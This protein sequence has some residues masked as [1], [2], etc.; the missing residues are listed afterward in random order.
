VVLLALLL[1]GAGAAPTTGV[2]ADV[3]RAAQGIIAADN[4]SDIEGV[5]GFYAADAIL[6]PPG[7]APVQGQAAIRQRYEA[8]FAAYAPA[9]EG[10]IDEL[11]VDGATAFVRGHNGG[12][13]IPRAEALPRELDDVYLMLLRRAPDGAWRIS[14]LIWHRASPAPR[15]DRPASR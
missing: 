6:M 3:R 4:T 12:R 5:L 2:E 9:I 8:L 1:A 15:G 13:L 11:A 7:E 10:R 14:H